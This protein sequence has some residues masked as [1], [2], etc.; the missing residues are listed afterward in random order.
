MADDEPRRYLD[1]VELMLATDDAH[2][3]KTAEEWR[4]AKH[5]RRL[6]DR[7]LVRR[8]HTCKPPLVPPC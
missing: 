1:F 6:M 3:P 2:V 8:N 5:Y 4:R 7:K